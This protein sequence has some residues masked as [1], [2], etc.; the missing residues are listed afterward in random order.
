MIAVAIGAI[1]ASILV[2]Y[3]DYVHHGHR[4]WGNEWVVRDP[5][6]PIL[7]AVYASA[8]ND[9]EPTLAY[10]LWAD[11]PSITLHYPPSWWQEKWEYAGHVVHVEGKRVQRV[12]GRLQLFVAV[13]GGRPFPV[14]L[15]EKDA[16]KYFG[17]D[18]TEFCS[19][20]DFL[21]FWDLL[22]SKYLR[23]GHTLGNGLDS[24]GTNANP[25]P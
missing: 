23:N 18:N 6:V 17:R 11:D 22:Q 7:M 20:E 9:H 2:T 19:E 10:F 21:R 1:S 4:G 15:D 16:K 24:T 3:R 5:E 12:T 14:I 25:Q 8:V 13:N